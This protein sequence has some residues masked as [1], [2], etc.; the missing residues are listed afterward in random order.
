MKALISN[1]FDLYHSL[2]HHEQFIYNYEVASGVVTSGPFHQHG[3]ALMSAWITNHMHSKVWENI[4]YPF[5]N[6]NS[7]TIGCLRIDK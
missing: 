6:F 5:T 7:A 4:T 2:K 3:L 1:L